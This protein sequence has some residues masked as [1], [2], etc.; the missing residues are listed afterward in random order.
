MATYSSILAWKTPWAE[1]PG[2]LQSVGS[3]TVRHDRAWT[4]KIYLLFPVVLTKGI[5]IHSIKVSEKEKN[6][7]HMVGF[8]LN[9]Y[10]F[11]LGCPGSSTLCGLFSSCREGLLLCSR[12]A[13][14]SHCGGFSCGAR[15]LG[16]RLSSCG[17]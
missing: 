11:I 17:T 8:F 13:Q 2:R 12:V 5:Q 3:Q 14:A 10:L 15:T 1:E 7:T 16:H 6:S 9:I 4:Q